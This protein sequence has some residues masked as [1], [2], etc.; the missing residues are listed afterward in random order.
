MVKDIKD[1]KIGQFDS[2]LVYRML[3]ESFNYNGKNDLEIEE[4]GR[5][6]KL[7]NK[8]GFEVYL[9]KSNTSEVDNIRANLFSDFK[10]IIV[11]IDSE[12]KNRLCIIGYRGEGLKNG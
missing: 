4:Q 12:D 7:S 1:R 5:A 10:R 11:E 2:E 8:R 9:V 3:R 6:I